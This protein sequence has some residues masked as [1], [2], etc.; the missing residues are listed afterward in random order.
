M[1][2]TV[3]KTVGPGKNYPSL[4]A[5]TAE[6]ADL[7]SRGQVK[8]FECY[9]MSDTTAASITGWTTTPPVT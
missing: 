5:L 4:A 2:T 9:A 3:T 8:V 7:V 6:A 1:N